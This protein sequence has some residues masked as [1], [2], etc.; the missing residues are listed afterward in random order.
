M[1]RLVCLVLGLAVIACAPAAIV[2]QSSPALANTLEPATPPTV[3]LMALIPVASNQAAPAALCKTR[4]WT[5][6]NMSLDAA[7]CVY[8]S[9]TNDP[10]SYRDGANTSASPA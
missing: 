8:D 5:S 7:C 3:S 10:W 4:I 1:W 9:A 2:P 6:L